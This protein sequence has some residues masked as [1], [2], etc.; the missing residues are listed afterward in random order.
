MMTDDH[1]QRYKEV[2]LRKFKI[3]LAD[4]IDQVQ[5][6]QCRLDDTLYI[7]PRRIEIGKMKDEGIYQQ[8]AIILD[9]RVLGTLS[10]EIKPKT[11]DDPGLI[12][13][14]FQ[15]I[16]ALKIRDELLE[17]DEEDENDRNDE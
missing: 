4:L 3:V 8:R 9:N 16:A 2:A 12:T 15:G 14:K 17:R 6:M 1:W 13:I 11:F 7:D 10:T 5:A